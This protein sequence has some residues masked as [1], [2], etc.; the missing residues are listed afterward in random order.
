[1]DHQMQHSLTIVLLVVLPPG[2]QGSTSSPRMVAM[3][4]RIARQRKQQVR[5]RE[6]SAAAGE[7][8]SDNSDSAAARPR[9]TQLR[10]GSRT[11]WRHD[12][13][14]RGMA[15]RWVGG[16]VG[17]LTASLG[18]GASMRLGAGLHP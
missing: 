8:S 15:A 7:G 5:G 2:K 6:V 16:H 18:R 12:D 13:D 11:L 3:T 17:D 10:Q 4:R 1:M 9:M 14:L